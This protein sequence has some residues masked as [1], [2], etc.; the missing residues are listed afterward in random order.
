VLGAY[1]VLYPNSRVLTL[2]LVFAVKIAAC[3]W[4]SSSSTNSSKPTT[5][6]LGQRE[7]WRRGVL[8]AHRRVLFGVFVARAFLASRQTA[9]SR[10]ET[11]SFG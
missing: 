8:R 2:V 1:F 3:S 7:R 10:S 6:L 9:R 4:A 5:A 11:L